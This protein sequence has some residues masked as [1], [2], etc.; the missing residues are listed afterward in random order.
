[1][2]FSKRILLVVICIAL[3]FVTFATVTDA[4]TNNK[5][6]LITYLTQEHTIYGTKYKLNDTDKKAISEYISKDSIKDSQA[7][8]ALEKLKTAE[9]LLTVDG[10]QNFY[11]NPKHYIILFFQ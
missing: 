6:E 8:D 5:T 10:T 2:A 7:K 11:D 4:G 3:I 9:N 1:M